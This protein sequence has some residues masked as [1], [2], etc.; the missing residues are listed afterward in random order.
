[1][2]S[3]VTWNSWNMT[4]LDIELKVFTMFSWRT[5]SSRWKSMVYL[6]TTLTLG[7][8]PRQR[9]WKGEGQE[10]NSWITFTLPKVWESVREWAHTLPSGFPLWELESWGTSKFLK[11]DLKGQNSLDW[12]NSYTIGK[13][14]RCK[15]LKWVCDALPSHGVKPTWGSH[16]VK[17]R[18]L[19]LGSTLRLPT[20]ERGRGLSWEPRD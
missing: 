15:C 8:W 16:K 3:H 17:L 7:S 6:V 13:L 5:I 10:C 4:I 14:L 1:M 19:R 18:K 12:T 20:L 2:F 11:N 9:A